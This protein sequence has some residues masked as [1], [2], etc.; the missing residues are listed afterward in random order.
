M[1]IIFLIIIGIPLVEIFVMI[2]IGS[3]VGAFNTIM[4]IFLTAVTGIYFYD[5]TVVQKAK[6]IKPSL[7]L[8]PAFVSRNF[9]F[10]I[11]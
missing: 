1:N 2:K 5:K 8:N 9:V 3:Y 11:C 4:L 10:P 6:E 7:K